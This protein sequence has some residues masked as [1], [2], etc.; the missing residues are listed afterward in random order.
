ML[1]P[2]SSVCTDMGNFPFHKKNQNYFE[3]RTNYGNLKKKIIKM[4]FRKSAPFNILGGKSNGMK[5][6]GKKF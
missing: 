6:T 2:K 1:D 5:I 3:T 4:N